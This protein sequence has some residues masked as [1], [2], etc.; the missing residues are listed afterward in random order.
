M[1]DVTLDGKPYQEMHVDG[2]AFAQTFLYPAA[3]MRQRQARIKAGEPV[4]PVRAFVIRNGRLDPDWASID[5][6]TLSIAERAISTMTTSSGY[7]D[8][9]RIYNNAQRDD[10]EY[11]LAYIGTDFTQ[12]LPAPFDSSYMRALYDYGY[13]RGRRGYAWAHKPPLA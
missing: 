2:G 3:V 9:V 4:I 10:I 12:K 6:R 5:R 8:V 1:F 11:N 7:N 13:Q